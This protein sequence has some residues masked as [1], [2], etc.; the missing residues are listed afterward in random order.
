MEHALSA[1]AEIRRTVDVF[2]D[3]ALSPQARSAALARAA[4]QGVAELVRSGRASPTYRVF[5]DGREGEPEERVKPDGQITY[6]FGSLNVAAQFALSF[7]KARSP[8]KS[9][10]YKDSFVFAFFTGGGVSLT[11]PG[12]DWRGRF[13]GQDG[14]AVGGRMVPADQVNFAKIGGDV[15][16]II[17]FNRQPY[18]R[19]VD[20]Q[21][22]G[23]APLKFNVAPGLFEDAAREISKRFGASVEARRIYSVSFPGQP[24]VKRGSR[25]GQR[26]QSPALVIS[27]R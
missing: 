19:R 27:P 10:R 18:S 14:K 24:V 25:S 2:I 4:R 1:A 21:M 26:V 17:I 9:G 5:V 7:L 3:Q 22:D 16:E 15:T 8:A 20:V 11:G 12:R 23:K 6:L 13:T